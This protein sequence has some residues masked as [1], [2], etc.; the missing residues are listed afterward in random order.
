M[1]QPEK[2]KTDFAL[3]LLYKTIQNNK[4]EV[5]AVVIYALVITL[6]SF[7]TPLVVQELVN[8][9]AFGVALQPLIIL[10]V[11][12]LL[13][14]ALMGFFKI[15]QQHVVEKVQM[16]LFV[17]RSLEI[18]EVISSLN[19]KQLKDEEV[20]FFFEVVNLQK[21][22]VKL[23]L[24]GLSALVQISIGLLLLAFY[25]PFFLLLDLVFIIGI[26]VVLP[27]S[28]RGGLQ[29]SLDESK[30][31]YALFHW[32]KQATEGRSSL[33][34]IGAE[35]FVLERSDAINMNYLVYRTEHFRVNVRQTIVVLVLQTIIS[36][37]LL[38]LGGY[39]VIENTLT[40]GQLIAAELVIA[41]VIAAL[42]K[43]SAQIPAFY[44]FLT[45]LLKLSVFDPDLSLDREPVVAVKESSSP[46]QTQLGMKLDCRN[47]RFTHAG[48]GPLF[49]GLDL[50]V[51]AGQRVMI[52]GDPG[53][54]KSTLIKLLVGS[55]A[56]EAGTIFFDDKELRSWSTERLAS[57]IGVL[58]SQEANIFEA[59]IEENITLGRELALPLRDLLELVCL[60][61]DLAT[62]PKAQQTL[63]EARGANL[64][65]SQDLRILLARALV[66]RPRL[67]LIDDNFSNLELNTRLKIYQNLQ[68]YFGSSLS[69]IMCGVDQVFAAQCDQRL[70]LDSA[71]GKLF[72][73]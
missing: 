8:V 19:K 67:L 55:L 21:S 42:D 73:L 34:Q 54:G 58:F 30:Q 10:T 33:Q 52:S 62:L 48:R 11:L 71:T 27:I 38:G 32:L 28:G 49:R 7:V 72:A 47:I 61:E 5:W 63:V 51:K 18:S 2:Q 37:G 57:E 17:E 9:I 43:V 16:R 13:G 53:S 20:N 70:E 45:A 44:D 22:S 12:A 65:L 15:L 40:L 29:S 60:D 14:A 41:T 50:N 6:L 68:S 56:L 26:G 1:I 24:D 31:K 66:T 39:L 36:A 46:A 35:R 3:G 23:L 25:H 64:S 4:N 69:V 59:S